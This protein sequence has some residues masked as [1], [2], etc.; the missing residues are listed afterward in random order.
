MLQHISQCMWQFCYFATNPHT[1]SASTLHDAADDTLHYG[2]HV[3][4]QSM[5]PCKQNMQAKHASK[6]CNP[7]TSGK[8]KTC[9]STGINLQQQQHGKP[10]T[11][12]VRAPPQRP[13][14]TTSNVS[15]DSE[16]TCGRATWL[17]QPWLYPIWRQAHAWGCSL[18][19]CFSTAIGLAQQG[20]PRNAHTTSSSWRSSG[21]NVCASRAKCCLAGITYAAQ[22]DIVLLQQEQHD[23]GNVR[24]NMHSGSTQRSAQDNSNCLPKPY[25]SRPSCWRD[26]WTAWLSLSEAFS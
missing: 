5:H 21:Q 13:N 15:L 22:H 6:T 17:P 25:A 4:Q 16:S 11:Q 12:R 19:Q 8:N 1:G 7:H 23:Q 18:Q 24:H 9:P 14:C 2:V 10:T 20:A 3:M 26:V